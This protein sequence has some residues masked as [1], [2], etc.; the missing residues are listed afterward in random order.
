MILGCDVGGTKTSV[1]LFERRGDTLERTRMETYPSREHASLR[2][3][4]DT[5]TGGSPAR[6]DAAGVG[7]AG[8]VVNGHAHTTNLPW[9]VDASQL[10]EQLGLP[11]VTLINDLEA[12]AWAVERL[13]DADLDVLYDG[14]VSPQGTIAVIAAGTGLGFSALVRSGGVRV[15]LASEGGHA[16]FAAREEIEIRL[17]RHLAARFGHVSSERVL[18]GPGLRNIYEFLRDTGRGEEPAWLLEEMRTSDPSAVISAA[19]LSGRSALCQQAMRMFIAIYG[20]ESGNW[21]LRT[22]ATGGVYLGGGIAPKLFS[23]ASEQG[24][25]D[26]R[27]IF[28][29][30]FH[31]SGRMRP[32]LET[33]GVSVILH[34]Q[35]ALLGA[36]YCASRTAGK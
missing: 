30:G 17:L 29:N 32:L 5:F 26:A 6:L 21:A 19:G 7:V 16:D 12:H 14:A 34:D 27:A 22:L 28:L 23:R 35:A 24:A 10:A 15:S 1:A 25:L 3:I 8:P 4:I 11:S 13:G 31:E 2:E 36:A 9:E 18:S 33:M 20:A